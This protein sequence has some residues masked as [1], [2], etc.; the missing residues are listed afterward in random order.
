[1]SALPTTGML[2]FRKAARAR[3]G[4]RNQEPPRSSL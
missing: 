3:C 1:M 4:L 2:L